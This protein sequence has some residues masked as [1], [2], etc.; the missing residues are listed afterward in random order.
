MQGIFLLLGGNIGDRI[1]YLQKAQKLIVS[2]AGTIKNSS[3]IYETAP[4]GLSEQPDFLNQT[5]EIESELSASDLLQKLLAIEVSLGRERHHQWN[6]RTIDIDIL[7]LG[8]QVIQEENLTIPH[9][10]LHL[11][12]FCLI[13]LTEIAPQI[14]HPVFNQTITQLLNTCEDPL[15]VRKYNNK[16]NS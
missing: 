2:N 6:A 15:E 3:A 7:L 4:W 8:N 10:R 12:K 1:A 11:R 16:I 5:L 13:P 9:P 14:I